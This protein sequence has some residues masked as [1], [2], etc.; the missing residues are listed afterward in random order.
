MDVINSSKSQSKLVLLDS[1][2]IAHAERIRNICNKIIQDNLNINS[3][4]DISRVIE[5]NITQYFR[6]DH[7]R[8]I[9]LPVFLKLQNLYGESIQHKKY[10]RR[11][12]TD[13]WI[14]LWQDKEGDY[15]DKKQAIDLA[16]SF[17]LEKVLKYDTTR[18]DLEY[19]NNNLHRNDF[20]SALSER[21]IRYNQVLEKLGLELNTDS[22]KWCS[23]SW[24]S[25]GTPRTYEYALNNAAK[26]LS[27]LLEDYNYNETKMTSQ[28]YILKHHQDF[29]GAL[30]RYNLDFY[31]VLRKSGHPDDR[32]RKKWWFFDND[33][34]GNLL[35]PKDQ[36]KRII[37]FFKRKILPIFKKEGLIEG[38]LGLS[39]DEAYEILK[40]TKFR[41]FLSA[42][43]ARNVSFGCM[44][45]T[46]G[47]SPRVTQ[48]QRAGTAFHWI[49]E[50]YLMMHTR[51][52][53]NC[54]SFYEAKINDENFVKPDNKIS[55]NENFRKL[56]KYAR[57]VPLEFENIHIDYYL[58]HSKRRSQY[59]FDKGYQ[60]DNSI[61][62][63]VPLNIKNSINTKFKNIKILCIHDFCDFVGFSDE[64][65]E[66]FIYY[67]KLALSSISETRIGMKNLHELEQKSAKCKEKLLSDPRINFSS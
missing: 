67:A 25:N 48:N 66:D 15:I 49:G 58:F 42:A 7:R 20:I 44:L 29:Y 23:L 14:F 40:N 28:Q 8:F 61:L 30:R 52:N 21:G 64:I 17:L 57:N 6:T 56:S 16:A 43:N 2:K 46:E 47:Y 33:K 38:N 62:L 12:T 3:Y 32:F 19:I 5:V 18:Y 31:K 9:K 37:Q 60:S 59:K 41:G 65:R 11:F 35:N 13:K 36:E 55:I 53:H 27:S 1:D 50:Y 39:Y 63:L 24:S 45:L 26:H 22:K 51:I 4:A 34:K 54:K 10:I